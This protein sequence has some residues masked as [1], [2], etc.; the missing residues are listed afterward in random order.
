MGKQR[1]LSRPSSIV[2]FEQTKWPQQPESHNDG[3][4]IQLLHLSHVPRDRALI[5]SQSSISLLHL[6]FL[7]FFLL[8]PHFSQS[9]AS[10]NI[11]TTATSTLTMT[12]NI[13]FSLFYWQSG[14]C[15]CESKP[16]Q[17]STY[18][19]PPWI[20]VGGLFL[21][22]F[23]LLSPSPWGLKTLC[24]MESFLQMH[25]FH[26]RLLVITGASWEQLGKDNDWL[27]Q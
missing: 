25:Q 7:P 11:C 1:F 5:F 18:L 24:W 17:R 9:S 21:F 15:K 14:G 19:P 22:V 20:G 2:E 27:E 13:R 23:C 8:S 26:Q 3:Q 12:Q 10:G 4:L 16:L 6:V